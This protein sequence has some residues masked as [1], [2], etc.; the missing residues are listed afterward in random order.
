MDDDGSGKVDKKE[1]GKI[2]EAIQTQALRPTTT[3]HKSPVQIATADGGLVSL[4]FGA[5]GKQ[6]LSPAMFKQF[7][8][9]MR[10]EMTR[11][12]YEWYNYKGTGSISARDFALSIVGCARLKHVDGYLDKVH[13]MPATLA[14]KKISFE[15]FKAFRAVWARLKRLSVALEFWRSSSGLPFSP[16]E[17]QS[18]VKRVMQID[19][20]DSVV[21]VIF[22]LFDHPEGLNTHFMLSVM[23]RSYMTGP[24]LVDG[25]KKAGNEKSFFD[26]MSEC[27]KKRG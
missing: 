12:E 10:D 15:E 9:E 2:L 20:S 16:K 24:T 25:A 8:T 22:Y 23:D 26:C 13:E 1:F 4:F 14:N 17:F 3:H 5:D 27:T 7:V 6:Q 18:L 19:L 21:D 11:L